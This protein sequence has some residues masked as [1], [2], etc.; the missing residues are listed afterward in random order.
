MI[1]IP[2][3]T[4]GAFDRNSVM[5]INSLRHLAPLSSGNIMNLN[6][7]TTLAAVGAAGVMLGA[8]A[9]GGMGGP[10]F[11]NNQFGNG[12]FQ[13]PQYGNGQVMNDPYGQAQ[14]GNSQYGNNQ[15]GNNQYGNNQYGNNQYGNNQ[16]GNNQYGNNQYGNNQYGNNQYGNV[17]QGYSGQYGSG[18]QQGNSGQYGSGVQQGNSGQFGSGVQQGNSG[19]YGSGVQQGNSGSFSAYGQQSPSGQ[20]G[21][22]A[23]GSY[24]RQTAPNPGAMQNTGFPYPGNAQA[25]GNGQYQ[26]NI[27]YQGSMQ[28]GNNA[29][30]PG[31]MPAGAASA[32]RGNMPSAGNPAPQAAP[33]P[34]RNVPLP[35]PPERPPLAVDKPVRKGQKVTLSMQPLKS[36]TAYLDWNVKDGRCDIDVSAFLLGENGKVPGDDWFVFYGQPESPDASVSFN[37]SARI[38]RQSVHIDFSKVSANVKKVTFVLTINEA[39]EQNLNFSMVKDACIKIVEDATG[40]ELAS[41]RMDE[42]YDNVISMMIGEVYAYKDNWKFNAIGNGVARDLEGLCELYGVQVSD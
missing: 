37:D 21:Q 13:N 8:M 41:F 33:A 6:T 16:Y 20:Y 23:P 11:N 10:G 29:P 14:Y 27:P 19:Q 31:N 39:T 5:E 2:F 32:N 30:S 24:S 17:Q 40:N 9:G 15:Y 18:V 25:G 35:P 26:G 1:D 12:Q 34:A 36:I 4:R 7:V 3:H 42:Y 22:S 28:S 38:G